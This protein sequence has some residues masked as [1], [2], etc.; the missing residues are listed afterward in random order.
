MCLIHNALMKDPTNTGRIRAQAIKELKRRREGAG[1][2]IV[3][4]VES[5]G[6]FAT[7]QVIDAGVLANRVVYRYQLD[8]SI[9]TDAMIRSIIDKWFNTGGQKPTR[10]FFDQYIAAAYAQATAIETSRIGLLADNIENM[11]QLQ[12]EFLL[13]SPAYQS[14]LNV[15]AS[16]AFEDMKDFS[17]DAGAPLRY[18]LTEMMAEGKGIRTITA[19]MRE[20]WPKQADYRLER[21]ARTEIANAHR[22]ARKDADTD[23]RDRLGLNVKMQWISQLAPTTRISHADQHLKI[24]EIEEVPETYAKIE[25]GSINCLCL[26]QSVIVT[27]SGEIL[28]QR[29][30]TKRDEDE[31]ARIKAGV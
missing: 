29:K 30:I 7:R 11:N 4:F 15:L 10:Y 16:R 19:R 5:L 1:L 31:L 20:E 2:E 3:A 26:Q 21:I 8:P 27:E 24:M 28:G 25:G 18:L 14:R 17:G 9:D 6:R 23:A 12:V 13:Q 22:S